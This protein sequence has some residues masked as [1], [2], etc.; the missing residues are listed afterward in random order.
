MTNRIDAGLVLSITNEFPNGKWLTLRG[1]DLHA[2]KPQNKLARNWEPIHELR[3]IGGNYAFLI[4]KSNFNK[5]R[6]ILLAGPNERKIPF[7]FSMNNHSAI[8]DNMV[9]YV[10]KATDLYK[11]FQQHFHETKQTTAAQ[12]QNGLVDS[13]IC[14]NRVE[15]ISFM[16]M[17]ALIKYRELPGDTHV[18]NRDLLVHSLCAK[19]APPFNI[20]SER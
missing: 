10:G 17:N 6:K 3:G 14:N 19:F 1:S 8:V 7:C 20:K 18:A 2:P 13:G 11:R 12:V 9:V 5:E 16:F 15:A 4:P